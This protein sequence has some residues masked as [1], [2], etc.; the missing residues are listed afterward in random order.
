MTNAGVA[1][2]F[3]VGIMLLVHQLG[4]SRCYCYVGVWDSGLRYFSDFGP[5]AGESVVGWYRKTKKENLMQEIEGRDTNSY[6]E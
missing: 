1:R 2:S 4:S 3:S 5:G 6:A